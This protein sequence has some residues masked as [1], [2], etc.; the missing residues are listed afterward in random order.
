MAATG[1]SATHIIELFRTLGSEEA[2]K[3]I[4][5]P[6]P[7]IAARQFIRGELSVGKFGELLGLNSGELHDFKN[8]CSRVFEE[9]AIEYNPDTIIAAIIKDIRSRSGI[10]HEWD[11]IDVDVRNEIVAAWR[12]LFPTAIPR[13]G[14]WILVSE[15][16]PERS[17]WFGVLDAQNE[18]RCGLFTGKVWFANAVEPIKAWCE[19][20]D[21]LLPEPQ[22]QKADGDH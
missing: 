3:Q 11:E 8:A 22:E 12:K 16:L 5:L 1:A 21:T 4:P 17:D 19:F 15:R 9:Q 14:R 20:P 13:P 2:I 6:S 18:K 10:R 7:L